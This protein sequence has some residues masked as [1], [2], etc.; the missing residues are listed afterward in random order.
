VEVVEFGSIEW[1]EIDDEEKSKDER[2]KRRVGGR[3]GSL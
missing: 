1:V 2:V 3:A